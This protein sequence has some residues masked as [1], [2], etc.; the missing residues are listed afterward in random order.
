MIHAYP[1]ARPPARF[2]EPRR[3]TLGR[4][5]S[6]HQKFQTRRKSPTRDLISMLMLQ[7][8]IAVLSIVDL[9]LNNY[10]KKKQNTSKNKAM[11]FVLERFFFF[12][13]FISGA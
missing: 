1:F 11:F 6:H 13:F 8:Q 10:E 7:K 12:Y 9:P 3:T 2:V 5:F 4:T